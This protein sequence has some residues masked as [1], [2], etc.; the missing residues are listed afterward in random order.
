MMC[1]GLENMI[2]SALCSWDP[3]NKQ[4][5]N[6]RVWGR[7]VGVENGN[8]VLQAER[9]TSIIQVQ[10]PEVK[11]NVMHSGHKRVQ[12]GWSTVRRD[13]TIKGP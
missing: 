9:I 5:I 8:T 12:S 7:G 10:F 11:E 4:S 1:H 3:I 6:K 2:N 13:Q